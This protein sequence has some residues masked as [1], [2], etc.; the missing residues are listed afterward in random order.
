MLRVRGALLPATVAPLVFLLFGIEFILRWVVIGSYAIA[1]A[2]DS[3]VPLYV[4][5][6]MATL[7]ISGL[8][9]SLWRRNA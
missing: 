1:R 7:L 3:Q 6:A 4:N 9:L 2:G 5:G 8:L